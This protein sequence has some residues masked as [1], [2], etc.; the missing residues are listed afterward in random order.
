[1]IILR[2]IERDEE[3]M[4]ASA[5]VTESPR[6]LKEG[7][8]RLTEKTPSGAPT[9][10]VCIETAMGMPIIASEYRL[11]ARTCRDLCREA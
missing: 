8:K 6:L 5:F 2:N 7:T 10:Q 9:I 3:R 11:I 4:F 1:M